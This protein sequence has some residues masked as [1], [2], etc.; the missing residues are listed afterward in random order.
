MY[1][2]LEPNV[3]FG[4][5]S[6]PLPTLLLFGVREGVEEHEEG[7]GLG[8]ALWGDPLIMSLIPE[9]R[10]KEDFSSSLCRNKSNYS[11]ALFVLYWNSD[12]KHIE[13]FLHSCSTC[14]EVLQPELLSYLL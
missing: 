5:C 3:E 7:V 2:K 4:L 9:Y 1:T 10:P 8:A 13:L 11:V 6:P 12:F 14:V